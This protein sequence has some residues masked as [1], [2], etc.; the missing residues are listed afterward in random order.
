ME[1]RKSVALSKSTKLKELGGKS[2]K[3]KSEKADKD[4]LME[5][6]KLDQM[7]SAA[8]ASKPGSFLEQ[9]KKSKK[10]HKQDGVE[11]EESE[12]SDDSQMIYT[13]AMK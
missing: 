13:F 7:L 11:S 9:P 5:G 10:K 4:N 12:S 8:P 1:A 3:N 2:G 6:G